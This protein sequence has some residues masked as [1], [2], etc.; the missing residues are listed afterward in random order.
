MKSLIILVLSLYLFHNSYSQYYYKD[1]IATREAESRAGLLK[2][3]RIRNVQLNSFEGDGTAT[4][5]FTGTQT[6]SP[7]FLQITTRLSSQ[8]AAESQLV[9]QFNASGK[10][11]KT[12][13][14]TE[15]ASS[16]SDYIYNAA[17]ALTRLNNLSISGGP[18]LEREAHLW[19]YNDSGKPTKLF[20]IKNESDTIVVDFLLDEHS[21]HAGRELPVLYYYYD[22]QKRLTD[23]AG[24]NP[25]ARRILPTHVFEYDEQGRI[26]SMLVVPEGSDQYQNWIYD[27]NQSGLKIRETC[28]DKKKSVQG[29]IEYKYN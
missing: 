14:T 29:R 2:K 8:H 25:K 1:I 12:M 7:D 19:I 23:I 6:V 26:A 18:H 17:G 4:E 5:G 22:D 15:G 16:H 28:Y 27:Y 11:I 24:Y 3:N 10:L 9:S 13:D 20:R 21:R